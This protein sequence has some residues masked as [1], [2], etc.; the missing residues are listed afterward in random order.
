MEFVVGV[1]ASIFAKACCN[2]GMAHDGYA[3]KTRTVQDSQAVHW[4]DRQGRKSHNRV[5]LQHPWRRASTVCLNPLV[6]QC[7]D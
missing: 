6:C 1:A 4:N 2:L 5:S 3:S 7:D